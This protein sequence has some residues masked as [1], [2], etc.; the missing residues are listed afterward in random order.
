[1]KKILI[2]ILF[3]NVLLYANANENFQLKLYEKIFTAIFN[4][5]ILLVY[6]DERSKNI[7]KRSEIFKM[8]D[9]CNPANFMMGRK[10]TKIPR[11]CENKP[12]FATSYRGFKNTKNCFGAFYW[13]KGR[14][15]IK[16]RLEIIEKFNLNLPQ[17]FR[18]YVE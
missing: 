2:I 4:K 5:N 12:L 14:P 17:R 9:K 10:F 11:E 16:F 8:M 15:Q 6:A 7:L 1:L 18:R 13:K 3:I